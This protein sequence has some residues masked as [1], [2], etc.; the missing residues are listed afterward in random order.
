MI[1]SKLE[2]VFLVGFAIRGFCSRTPLDEV[3]AYEVELAVIEA[4]NNAIKHAY[5]N[6]K[7]H[8]V[9]IQVFFHP[10]RISFQIIDHGRALNLSQIPSMDFDPK[11]L[12]SLPESGM[13]FH[14]M[15]SVMDNVEYR[16]Y[17]NSNI[18]TLTKFYK[19]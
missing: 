2:L 7:G 14:I 3:A 9:E 12:D 11:D 15:Q 17:G 4:I 8:Q 10:D 6:Q 16:R 18:L 13:G 5:C 19:E 1:D